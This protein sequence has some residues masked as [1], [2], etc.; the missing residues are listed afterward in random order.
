MALEQ[1]FIGRRIKRD[2]ITR[3]GKFLLSK[4][5]L[6]QRVH[7]TLLAK[8]EIFLEKEDVFKFRRSSYTGNR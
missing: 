6:L 1:T 2:I 7:L 8:N 5:T 3:E 4:N